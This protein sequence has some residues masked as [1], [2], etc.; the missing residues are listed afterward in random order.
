VS[1]GAGAE[2]RCGSG[3]VSGSTEMMRLFAPRLCNTGLKNTRKKKR[4]RKQG[5]GGI[6]NY[7][8]VREKIMA[9]NKGRNQEREKVTEQRIL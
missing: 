1:I 7:E 5:G 2:Q 4:I 3:S 8:N 9:N 6:D